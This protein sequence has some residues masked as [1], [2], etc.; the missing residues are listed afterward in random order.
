MFSLP[1]MV[2]EISMSA[3]IVTSLVLR[4]QQSLGQL[5]ILTRLGWKMAKFNVKIQQI[6]V[7]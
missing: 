3:I 5:I 2:T 7:G 4:Y 6:F 1:Q